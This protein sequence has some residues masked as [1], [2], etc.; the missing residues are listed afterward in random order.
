METDVKLLVK[1]P[2][3]SWGTIVTNIHFWKIK[4]YCV[5]DRSSLAHGSRTWVIK[6][7]G[8]MANYLPILILPNKRWLGIVLCLQNY[9]RKYILRCHIRNV[10][11]TGNNK[12]VRFVL[13]YYSIYRCIC[14]IFVSSKTFLRSYFF[15]FQFIYNSNYSKILSGERGSN[16]NGVSTDKKCP[17]MIVYIFIH[18]A[19]K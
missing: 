1:G 19:V 11:C 7:F 17:T 8:E 13:L 9:Y 15:R 10:L 14:N 2:Y 3:E 12:M 5:L 6:D 4:W 18:V 16:A